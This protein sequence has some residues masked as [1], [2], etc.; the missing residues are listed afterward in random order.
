M[1]WVFIAIKR[2]LPASIPLVLV[3]IL[4][5]V[6]EFQNYTTV[7]RKDDFL[8]I[9]DD[10]L[11][12]QYKTY[13][14][15]DA[16]RTKFI[17]PE[18]SVTVAKKTVLIR[19]AGL[20]LYDRG[21]NISFEAELPEFLIDSPFLKK[22]SQQLSE[23]YRKSA[24][25][26]TTVDWSLVWHGFREPEFSLRNWEGIIGVDFAHVTPNA[27]SLIQSYW[28]YTGG[29]HGNGGLHGQCFIDDQGSVRRL[30]LEDLFDPNS[31]WKKR[32]IDFCVS[33]LRCQEAT[34][35]SDGLVQN[36]ESATLSTDN[37]SRPPVAFR[38]DEDDD[39]FSENSDSLTIPTEQ[40]FCLKQFSTDDLTSFTLSPA[41]LRF[42]FSPCHV[43]TYADG[44]YTVGV[45]YRTIQDCIPVGSPTRRFMAPSKN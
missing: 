42:Y 13:H 39:S 6:F 37:S 43:G 4:A 15:G 16:E 34:F 2:F 3:A 40:P 32:L 9:T 33:D 36:P 11:A 30:N 23:D 5:V 21:H 17:G 12:V 26:F 44:V 29:A 10:Q 8:L 14:S 20:G 28:E 7:S 19:R 38:W 35:I 1:R 27:V 45:P 25:E 41:G 24:T 18:F 31:D 22:L